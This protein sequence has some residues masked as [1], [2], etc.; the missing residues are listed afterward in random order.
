MT[1]RLRAICQGVVL[2]FGMALLSAC[3]VEPVKVEQATMEAGV[4][5]M[6]LSRAVNVTEPFQVTP[7]GG[8]KCSMFEQVSK[9]IVES[10]A[11]E[12]RV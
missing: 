4:A 9:P 6:L 11:R 2:L 1:N 3:A 7:S 5:G 10:M 8:G 12:G